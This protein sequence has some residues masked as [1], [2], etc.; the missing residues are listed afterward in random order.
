MGVKRD[1]ERVSGSKKELERA[2][3]MLLGGSKRKSVRELKSDL[4]LDRNK[5]I[6]NNG[7]QQEKHSYLRVRYI[8]PCF[9]LDKGLS[10]SIMVHLLP[11]NQSKKKEV[12]LKRT[13]VGSVY[14]FQKRILNIV[15]FRAFLSRKDP[16]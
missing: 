16:K 15:P 1:L 6:R 2:S 10:L 3:E 12:A 11:S 13:H 7:C 14:T 4:P 5:S 8:R 9:I